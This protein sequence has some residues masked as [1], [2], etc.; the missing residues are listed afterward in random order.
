MKPTEVNEASSRTEENLL[1]VISEREFSVEGWKLCRF[2][3]SIRTT[4]NASMQPEHEGMLRVC[5]NEMNVVKSQKSLTA[6]G[7]KNAM[8]FMCR[9]E[10]NFSLLLC[11]SRFVPNFSQK[12]PFFTNTTERIIY[13]SICVSSCAGGIAKNTRTIY[14]NKYNISSR[15]KIES[16]IVVQ[17][18]LRFFK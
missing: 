8:N 7:E 6:G 10:L 2:A 18:S 11:F 17:L 14:Q 1:C 4:T 5:E 15:R 13:W 9:R 3:F 12:I 16:T